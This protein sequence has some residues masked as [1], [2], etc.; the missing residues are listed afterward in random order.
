MFCLV[1]SIEV[2]L[3]IWECGP[4]IHQ[5]HLDPPN[6]HDLSSWRSITLPKSQ[7]RPACL[8]VAAWFKCNPGNGCKELSASMVTAPISSKMD[9]SLEGIAWMLRG[10]EVNM[11]LQTL[12]SHTIPGHGLFAYM[13]GKFKIYGKCIGINMPYMDAMGLIIN[14][15]YYSTWVNQKQIKSWRAWFLMERAMVIPTW[16]ANG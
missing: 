16:T 15:H 2:C 13:E 14:H 10:W 12:F 6:C 8:F 7:V 5:K 3:S 11:L 9:I 4:T 1:E